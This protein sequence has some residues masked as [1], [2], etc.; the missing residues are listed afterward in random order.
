MVTDLAA[1]D[2]LFAARYPGRLFFVFG[3]SMVGAV[4]MVARAEGLVVAGVILM[5]P[6][7]WCGAACRTGS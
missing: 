1:I 6:A 7:V 4:A 2:R 5:A 3:E